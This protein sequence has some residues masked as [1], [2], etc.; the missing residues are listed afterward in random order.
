MSNPAD[1]KSTK[2]F[3]SGFAPILLKSVIKLYTSK[4]AALP[5]VLTNKQGINRF[6]IPTAF[7]ETP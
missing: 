3:S 2:N 1:N 6:G 5:D 4:A 7:D